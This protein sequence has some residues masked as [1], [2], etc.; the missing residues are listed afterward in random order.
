M[1]G[2]CFWRVYRVRSRSLRGVFRSGASRLGSGSMVCSSE[3]GLP[4]HLGRRI[5]LG[6]WGLPGIPNQTVHLLLLCGALF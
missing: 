2:A 6:V 1:F 4:G 5:S 3:F